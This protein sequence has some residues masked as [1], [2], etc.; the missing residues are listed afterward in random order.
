MSMQL[1]PCPYCRAEFDT[2]RV[3]EHHVGSSH[4]G[5]RHADNPYRCTTCDADLVAQ[6]EW[7]RDYREP[8]E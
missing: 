8:L 4:A 2:F 1:Y 5:R 6:M 7:L 3:L